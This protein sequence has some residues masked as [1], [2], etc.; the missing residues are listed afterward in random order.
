[1]YRQMDAFA[2]SFDDV[3][4]ESL[5]ILLELRELL[6]K[7]LLHFFHIVDSIY[8]VVYDELPEKISFLVI[9]L[10]LLEHHVLFGHL[11]VVH[12]Q[13]RNV[14]PFN[15]VCVHAIFSI[16]KLQNLISRRPDSLI[17]LHLNIFECFD[18][19][20]LDVSG[21][22]GFTGSV[23]NALSATHGV[24]VE[25]LR[26]QSAKEVVGDEALAVGSIVILT[27]MRQR[28]SVESK[29]YSLTFN[30]LLTH[31]CHDL[32]NVQVTALRARVDHIE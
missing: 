2:V 16:N 9:I 14:H 27:V 17:V 20:S 25:L 29:T 1:M 19:T 32:R 6:I 11:F 26:S 21:F 4:S 12:Q 15:E 28:P 10:I 22:G 30:I 23:D 13:Q 5:S 7:L 31:T 18:Q 24:E 3:G 8:D